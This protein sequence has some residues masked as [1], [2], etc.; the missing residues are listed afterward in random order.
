VNDEQLNFVVLPQV[1]PLYDGIS[2]MP[3]AQSIISFETKATIGQSGML[4]CQRRQSIV[5]NRI[6]RT[7]PA[8]TEASAKIIKLRAS[9]E[10]QENRG[11]KYTTPSDELRDFRLRN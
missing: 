5:L 3:Y 7:P 4:L 11:E 9:R 2:G 8:L 6:C 1:S 10:T